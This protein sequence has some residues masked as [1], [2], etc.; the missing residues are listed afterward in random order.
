VLEKEPIFILVIQKNIMQK[1]LG[2]H[3]EDNII[4]INLGAGATNK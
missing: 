3:S 4:A 2:Q 1:K